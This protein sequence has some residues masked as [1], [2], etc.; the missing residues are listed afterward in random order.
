MVQVIQENPKS[1]FGSLLGQSLG[2]GI[3]GGVSQGINF[4]NQMRL[5]QARGRG[6][7]NE[8][9][10][11]EKIKS[12]EMGLGTIDQMKEI[13]KRGKLG[14]GSSFSGLFSGDVRRDRAEY[15]Q[16]GRSLIP[17]VSSGVPIRNQREFEEYKKILT[18]PSASDAEI[19]GALGALENLLKR[20]ASQGEDDFTSKVMGSDKKKSSEI[21]DVPQEKQAETALGSPKEQGFL[22][23]LFGAGSKGL[24]KGGRNFSPLPNLG[25][26]NPELAERLMEEFL[27]SKEGGLEDVFEFAGE[28]IPAVAMG[29]GGIAKKG[30][31]ALI[32][33]TLKSGAKEINLPG[34]AQEA[35]NIGGMSVPGSLKALSSKKI[36]PAAA[37]KEIYG[38]LKNSG[39]SDKEITPFIQGKNKASVLAP[40]AK[41]SLSKQEIRSSLGEVGDV[42]YSGI[43]EEASKL[44]PLTGRGMA[45]FIHSFEEKLSK[46]PKH[47][48]K[49]IQS[50]V[51]EL[52]SKPLTFNELRDFEMLLNDKI[53]GAEGGRASIGILKDPLK[54]AQADL[55][56]KIFKKK[57]I[58]NEV[59]S[60]GSKF[61]DLMGKHE[62]GT[63]GKLIK[64]GPVGSAAAGIVTL[65]PMLLS[66]AGITLGAPMIAKQMLTN[67]RF[68][69]LHGK[70]SEAI[71]SGNK[72][73][74]LKLTQLM[75]DDLHK[76]QQKEG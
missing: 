57:E 62:E 40:F 26:I 17:L 31:Q 59:Y 63:I 32:G 46:I 66:A 34:W 8:T 61:A 52:F 38:A 68:Y 18:D 33:G 67:P 3:S 24:I 70:L 71:K 35:A 65:N 7:A 5:E 51:D 2:Q 12:L 53:K 45:S 21:E 13:V 69:N 72:T 15:E 75:M 9:K 54:K 50:D 60:R 76:I 58:A 44:P 27:P 11:M 4:A 6:L 55:S 1:S 28:N 22:S 73:A 29:E 25:A 41:K 43:R 10:Q 20:S 19:E 42:L 23:S 36:L 37:D 49:L 64:W 47:H 39:F 56:P 48:R 74:V 14:R 30:L 16:L